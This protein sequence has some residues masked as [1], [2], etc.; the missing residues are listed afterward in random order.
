[1][2]KE[3]IFNVCCILNGQNFTRESEESK[4]S[5]KREI[6]NS[7]VKIMQLNAL[8]QVNCETK[9]TIPQKTVYFF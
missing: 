3:N 9:Y 1:M 7:P 6:G 5:P 8:Q 4:I 2:K